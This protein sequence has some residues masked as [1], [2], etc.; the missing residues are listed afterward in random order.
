MEKLYY[1]RGTDAENESLIEFLDE[2]FFSEDEEPSG[3]RKLLP[4][5]YKDES[6][7]AHNNFIVRQND[8]NFRAA[9]GAFYNAFSVGGETLTSYCIGNV[10]VGKKF[11][12]NGYMIDLMNMAIDDIVAKGA[13]FAYLGGNRHRYAYF[14]FEPSANKY[15]FVFHRDKIKHSLGENPSKLRLQTVEKNDAKSLDFIDG[16]YRENAVH[17]LRKKEGL[18]YILCSWERQPYLL[19][20]GNEPVGYFIGKGNIRFVDEMTLTD[21]QYYPDAVKAVFE[22]SEEERVFFHSAEFE[23]DKMNFMIKQADDFSVGCDEASLILHFEKCIAA[24]LKAKTAYTRLCDGEISVCIHGKVADEKFK[25][26]VKNNSV[27]TEPFDGEAQ[28]ELHHLEAERLFFS[29]ASEKRNA[30]PPEIAQW[31]PLPMYIFDADKM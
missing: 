14:G 27:V 11:R 16:L 15:K 20:D 30:L 19:L 7:P 5:I 18:F 2:I 28:L 12:S 10:G 24:F 9:V 8:G 29:A 23:T 26:T 31:L 17:S 13:D 4:K 21:C 25:I 6:R 1:G 3:F 22:N